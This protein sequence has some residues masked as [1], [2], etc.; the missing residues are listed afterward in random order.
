VRSARRAG[1][2]RVS[3]ASAVLIALAIVAG[4]GAAASPSPSPGPPR[5]EIELKATLIDAFGSLWYCDPDFYPVGRD[6]LV[7]MKERWPEVTADPAAFAIV[8]ARVG[9][10]PTAQ[11][12]D[13]ERLTVYREWKMLN[14]VFLQPEADRFRFDY[15]AQPAPG[16]A[17][18]RRV[19]GLITPDGTITIE[20]DAPAG[21]PM[22]PICLVRGTRIATPA[23]DV[24][25]EAIRPGMSVWTVDRA[26]RRVAATVIDT[27]RVALGSG[28]TAVRVELADG[29]SLTASAG[30]PLA[31]GRTIGSLA[32]GDTVD[33]AVVTR[34]AT[35]ANVDGWTFDLLPSGD[36]G[37]YWADGVLLG[38]TLAGR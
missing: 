23:G 28:H 12:T 20:Q 38:S 30:H 16:A 8:A 1:V 3:L 5:S 4:C 15:L 27:G 11:L 24:T 29:R 10:D 26:G 33:G 9:V 6:E 13:E 25:I 19:A 34:L 14:A 2:T 35:V 32:V 21:E 18:G 22:C 31:D 36:T 7:A 37:T 17:E